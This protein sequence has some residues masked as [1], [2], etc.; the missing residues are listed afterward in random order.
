MISVITCTGRKDP[1]FKILADTIYANLQSIDPSGKFLWFEHIVVDMGLWHEPEYRGQELADAVKG[2][3]NY[4]HVAPK[5]NVWQGP[6]RLTKSDFYALCSARNTG[7]CCAKF[8]Y[9]VLFD[10]CL[11]ADMGWLQWHLQA[12]RMHIA[13][14]G[15]YE[16]I[17]NAKLEN[18]KVVSYDVLPPS[19]A[20]HRLSIVGDNPLPVKAPTNWTYGLNVGFPLEAALCIGGYDEKYDGAGGVEDN[21]FGIRLGRAGVQVYFSSACKVFQLMDTHDAVCGEIGGWTGF[22]GAGK[23]TRVQK[24]WLLK[25]GRMHYANER[26]IEVLY[27]QPNRVLPLQ[28]PNLLMERQRL[29]EGKGFTI[30]VEPTRD[31][32]D[33]QLL[34]DMA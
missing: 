18:G 7:L 31:W 32:R 30:P 27:E 15:T 8:N 1:R 28:G 2:R 14:A 33:N 11:A 24:E 5:P 25:D 4:K 17:K 20:D 23:K 26:L 19:N 13:L 29:S 9:I 22:E 6:T 21:D 3:F 34:V 10:D 16:S 12:A